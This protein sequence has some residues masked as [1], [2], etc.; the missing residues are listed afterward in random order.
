MINTQKVKVP[1]RKARVQFAFKPYDLQ[2]E[3]IDHID[4][5][6]LNPFGEE[7]LFFI[8]VF[9]R[10]SGKSW[11]AKYVLL[12]HAANRDEKCMWVAPSIPTARGHWN[13]L[14]ELIEKS[15]MVEAGFVTKI[16][17][18][19]KEIHFAGGGAISVR[20]AL[21]PDNL[22]G[23]SLNL[24][25]LDEAAFFRDGQY[26]WWSV[27]QPMVS[28]T[29]GK[30]IFTTT[31]NGRNWLYDLYLKGLDPKSRFYKSWTATSYSSPYQNVELLNDTKMNMPSL[32]WREEYM[33]EFL[34]D[35]GGVFAGVERAAVVN[36]ISYPDPE[37]DPDR[38]VAGIDIGFN[39]DYTCFTVIDTVTREQV[40]G[41]RFT[42]IGTVR[43][44]KR[45][46]ELMDIW[47]PR[48]THIEKNGVGEYLIDL[49]RLVVSG[50]N[51]DDMLGFINDVSLEDEIEGEDA[52]T[53]VGQHK[54]KAIHMNNELKRELIE[55]LSA[56]IEYGR[57]K[58]LA[59]KDAEDAP[60]EYAATQISEMSTFE[61]QPTASGMQITYNAAEGA[62]DD[63]ISA[64]AVCY[65]GV[66]KLSRQDILNLIKGQREEK[67]AYKSSPFRSK[68]VSGRRHRR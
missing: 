6:E 68:S 26:V 20:S 36:M 8:A 15:G 30:V 50:Q 41:E 33:A 61:R 7:Y 59:E 22:R 12:D 32:Q 63:T 9:G 14:V 45:I 3:I 60:Q 10:Q 55:R 67:K 18:A 39:N 23:A 11:L 57:L 17:Q 1:K 28:A 4:G 62:H 42:N 24:L 40:Y 58:I 16:S 47:Q 31:P 51:I 43:T 38:Y 2:Q 19:S 66:K 49:I 52:L 34:A 13:D 25:V 56:D 29:G 65:K 27:L 54:I 21:E 44:V 53:E 5:L 35:G 37:S 64:L 48:V 46:V